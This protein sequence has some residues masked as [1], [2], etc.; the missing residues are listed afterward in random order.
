MAHSVWTP[1]QVRSLDRL[2]IERFAIPGYELMTRAGQAAF[3]IA[4]QRW[5]DADRWLVLCGSGNNAGDGF[6]IARL[7]QAAGLQVTV[8][9]LADPLSLQGDAAAAWRDYAGS[10]GTAQPFS[11]ALIAGS[12]L[13]VDALL[14]TGLQRPVA[15]EYLAAIEAVNAGQRPVLALDV[16]SGLDS[17]NGTALGAAVRADLTVTFVGR[18]TGLYLGSG[19]DF[20]GEVEFAGLDIPAGAVQQLQAAPVFSLFDMGDLAGLLPPRPADA[21][22]GS[23]GHVLIVGGNRGMSGAVRLAGE[24]A[25]RAG[26]GL[27]TVATRPEHALWMPLTRP[28]LM[29]AG[30]ASGEDLGP[31]LK[32]A[33]LVACGPGLG[34]DPWAKELF[35][36]V[37]GSGLPLILDADALNL[38]AERRLRRDNWIL[39]PHP[40]EA[41]RLLG[42]SSAMVQ[43]ERVDAL[44]ELCRRYGGTVVLK[45]RG[46]LIG[47]EGSVPVLIDRGNPGMATAGMGDVLTGLVAGLAAQTGSTDIQTA[48]GAAFIHAA[49]GDAAAAT[50]ERGLLASDLFAQLRPWLN[51]VA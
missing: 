44:N 7:A 41:A 23:F 28:E 36:R 9:V 2:A 22:K 46:T 50:G 1:A 40:G 49:A 17:L 34:R 32:R 10:G 18:K 38:L 48:A 35:D 27:V 21:H 4:R 13:V 16:P 25:L 3:G 37:V 30:V 19:P 42:T 24:A 8:A 51:P 5:P 12:D 47:R 11:V 26:A 31:L 45:G 14:G 29:C 33:T 43:G 20:S 39:T 6:V 15:G